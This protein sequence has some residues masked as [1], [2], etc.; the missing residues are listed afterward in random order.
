MP[1]KEKI[2]IKMGAGSKTEIKVVSSS[3]PVEIKKIKPKGG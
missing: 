3:H 1:K 2:I